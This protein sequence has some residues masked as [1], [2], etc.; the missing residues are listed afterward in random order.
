M[1]DQAPVT[2]CEACGFAGT[3]DAKF[4][5]QCGQRLGITPGHVAP[6]PFRYERKWI[7]VLFAD[8]SRSLDLVAGTDPERAYE[9]LADTIA[10]MREAVDTHGGVVNRVAGDGIMAMF[11]A[12]IGAEDHAVSACAA[13][14]A[15]IEHVAALRKTS[16]DPKISTIGIRVGLAT[17]EVLVHPTAAFASVGYDATGE[18][19]HRASRLEQAATTGSAII[20]EE[21][22]KLA[23][24]RIEV[25]D[26]GSVPGKGSD[27]PMKAYSLVRLLDPA[28]TIQRRPAAISSTFVGRTSEFATLVALRD[29]ATAGRGAAVQ[30]T[31]DAGIGKSRLLH[32]FVFSLN[33]HAWTIYRCEAQRHRRSNF[34]A[35]INLIACVLG[36]DYAQTGRSYVDTLDRLPVLLSKDDRQAFAALIDSRETDPVWK[37]LEPRDRRRRIDQALDRFLLALTEL[38]PTIFL[39]ED[40]HWLDDESASV[41]ERFFSSI[42]D[43][44]VLAITTSRGDYEV[45]GKTLSAHHEI[46]LE[47]LLPADSAALL[48]AR[49]RRGPGVAALEAQLVRLTQGNPLFLEECLFSLIDTGTATQVGKE[50]VLARR[51]TNVRVPY[52][53]RGLLASRVDRVSEKD[54]DVLEAAAVIGTTV[55][56]DLLAQLVL[57][58]GYQIDRIA[59]SL[60]RAGF[61]VQGANGSPHYTFRHGLVREA[62]YEGIPLR[63]REITHARVLDIVRS[64]DGDHTESL[65]DHAMRANKFE[66]AAEYSRRAGNKAFQRDAK[67]EAVRFLD[68]GLKACEQWPEGPARD[69]MFFDISIDLRNPLFQLGRIGELSMRLAD[70]APSRLSLTDPE[71]LGR[72]YPYLSHHRWF[73]GDTTAALDAARQTL[74]VAQSLRDEAMIARAKFQEGLVWMSQGSNAKAIQAFTDVLDFLGTG[75]AEYQY[76]VNASLEVTTLNYVA[77]AFA[78]IGEERTADH[79]ATRAMTIAEQLKN[80]FASIFAYIALGYCSLRADRSKQAVPFL[81]AALSTSITGE[82][83]QLISVAASYLAWSHLNN[84]D[85]RDGLA[86]ATLSVETAEQ[87]GFRAFHPLRL[88]LLARALLACADPDAALRKGRE[89]R[90]LARIQQERSAEAYALQVIGEALETRHGKNNEAARL[91]FIE[92]FELAKNLGLKPQAE[93]IKRLLSD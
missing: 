33:D 5:Q 52:T 4:C 89:A 26:L 28:T 27:A 81:Q 25:I 1:T 37:M 55:S 51:I 24:G 77:R 9:V 66:L 8:I 7:T 61:L 2:V 57:L 74:A 45:G 70:A 79:F 64:W 34:N 84:Q 69:R 13:A 15:M 73:L 60:C 16:R 31:G 6:T 82:T 49:I 17:G 18:A 10:V 85:Y 46:R 62:V 56:P 87:M 40:V 58:E 19:V 78:D 72:Y 23:R 35:I 42:V 43:R 14:L 67:E 22:Y 93:A 83:P 32:E 48:N 30:I 76:G 59:R 54:K 68:Q 71:R 91:S 39:I 44:R 88:A 80:P 41:F 36:V 53:L 47:P 63:R 90:S 29:A 20:S 38:G 65:A 50:L 92:G 11:G 12:P 86:M 75:A 3:S 21:T